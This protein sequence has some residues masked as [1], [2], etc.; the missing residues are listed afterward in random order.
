MAAKEDSDE[1]VLRNPRDVNKEIRQEALR[2]KKKTKQHRKSVGFLRRQLEEAEEKCSNDVFRQL[3]YIRSHTD[4]IPAATG[5]P[6]MVGL[7]RFND[8]FETMGLALKAVIRSGGRIRT[9]SDFSQKHFLMAMA[10]LEEDDLDEDTIQQYVCAMRRF[11]DLVGKKGIVPEGKQLVRLLLDNGISAGTVG[12]QYVAEFAKGWRDQGIDVDALIARVGQYCARAALWLKLMLHFGLRIRE[13]ACLQPTPC[14][15]DTYLHVFRGTKGDKVRD[16][17]LFK[18]PARR[19]QQEAVIQE[20]MEFARMSKKGEIGF[21]GLKLEQSIDRM[22]AICRKFGITKAGLGIV[23]HG[24]RHQFGCDL[25]MDRSGLPAPVLNKVSASVYEENMQLF[26]AAVLFVSNALGHERMAITGAY[27]G[28]V[29]RR[30][31]NDKR[32]VANLEKL[33]LAA[34]AF[35]ESGVTEAFIVGPHALGIH[36]RAA[37]PFLVGVRLPEHGAAEVASRL[38]TLADRIT[39]T[40]GIKAH[41]S[42]VA[43]RPDD[44]VEFSFPKR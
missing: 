2:A 35:L 20:A 29:A 33:K 1:I 6:R 26:E 14:W 40:M 21:P 11:N 18:D 10:Q 19:A 16:V 28:T 24:L 41:V 44:G 23:P 38:P 17:P 27:A 43:A 34:P 25:L 8:I 37:G 42:V 32:I 13:V 15:K 39:E 7:K 5:R 3:D 4:G 22:R 30:S 12:R 9:L 31:K 36:P